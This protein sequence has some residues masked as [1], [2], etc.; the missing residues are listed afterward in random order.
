MLISRYTTLNTHPGRALGGGATGEGLSRFA[1]GKSSMA[2]SAFAGEA[3][4]PLSGVPDGYRSPYAWVLPQT[5]GGLSARNKLTGAGALIAAIAGGKNAEATLAG[6]GDLAGTGALIVSLVAALVGSGT[7]GSA[8][9]IAFLQLAA[10]LAGSGDLD[11][12]LSALA[13][14]SAA[15]SG[16]G[17]AG[18]TST[19]PG[20]LAASIVVTGDVLNSANV[21]ASVWSALAAANNAPGTMGEKLNDAGSASNPWTEVIESG[22]T[23]AEILRLIAA[24]AQGSAT[25]LESGNPVF[26]SIAGDKDRITATYVAGTRTVTDRDAS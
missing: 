26:K 21:G 18:A 14:A 2:R 25:G 4:D 11:G 8:G 12:A 9:A 22:M 10:T 5:A 20:A 7:I 15:L 13:H 24:A 19:A 6:S 3:W 17:D 23:A 1:F 16:S